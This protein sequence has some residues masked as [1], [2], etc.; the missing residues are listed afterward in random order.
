MNKPIIRHLNTIEESILE[1]L[2]W[3]NESKLWTL[4]KQ[5][6]LTYSNFNY[7]D[8]TQLN[9]P[10]PLYE[11]VGFMNN[12][13]I[14]H[15]GPSGSILSAA[16][17]TNS[18][19]DSSPAKPTITR[20]VCSTNSSTTTTVSNENMILTTKTL[21]TNSTKQIQVLTLTPTGSRTKHSK[22]G[23]LLNMTNFLTYFF[24]KF[25]NLAN[26]RL[27][28]LLDKLNINHI[29][30][31][32]D[33]SQTNLTQTLTPIASTSTPVLTPVTSSNI[34][35]IQT[36]N[37]E[38]HQ[39]LLKKIWNIFEYSL[40]LGVKTNSSLI[41]GRHLDQMLLCAV[42]LTCKLSNLSILF[43]DILKA[44]KSLRPDSSSIYR[45]VLLDKGEYFSDLIQFYNTIYIKHMKEF[46]LKIHEKFNSQTIN[47]LENKVVITPVNNLHLLS[48]VPRPTQININT[49]LQ[50]SSRKIINDR[51]IFISP[52]KDRLVSSTAQFVQPINSKYTGRN[53]LIYLFGE[54]DSNKI[55]N[56][57]NEMIKKNEIKVRTSNKR[58]FSDISSHNLPVNTSSFKASLSNE[59][60]RD[61]RV[62]ITKISSFGSAQPRT[63]NSNTTI[64][65][66]GATSTNFLSKIVSSKLGSTSNSS[67]VTMVVGSSSS[68]SQNQTVNISMPLGTNFSKRIQ[69]I[70]NERTN[71]N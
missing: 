54:L 28:N 29:L 59:D 23:R 46:A 45:D 57:I 56:K 24:R 6:K 21:P 47:S 52:I 4:I 1:L 67:L 42:Y 34:K 65:H 60:E 53:K 30:N 7:N 13:Q 37:S 36:Q 69:T 3:S 20:V 58:L 41:R 62:K 9:Y 39:I 22:N 40:C 14:S 31:E 12:T 38:K 17:L 11:E 15:A 16:V 68:S 32:Q 43:T 35:P 5:L 64:G 71:V 33:C 63:A 61:G 10:F 44:Y 66:S 26:L 51:P 50:F 25:Y 49:N 18:K 48:P 8:L 2:C 70:Q 19:N 55:V 27:R